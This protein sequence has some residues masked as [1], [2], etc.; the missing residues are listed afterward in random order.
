MCAYVEFV[1][2]RLL[3]ALDCDAVYRTANP[4]DWMEGISLVNKANFFESKVSNYQKASVM[5]RWSSRDQGEGTG[6]SQTSDFEF[7]TDADF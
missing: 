7:R 1:A 5:N 2:D 4:F 6:S 3:R